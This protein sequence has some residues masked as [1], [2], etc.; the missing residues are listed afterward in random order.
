MADYIAKASVVKVAVGPK[1][2]SRVA[3]FIRAGSPIPEGVDQDLLDALA[4]RGLIQLTPDNPAEDTAADD[5][6]AEA[7]AKAEADAAAKA[8]TD[9]EAAA[10]LAK[11]K[12][13]TSD[14]TTTA[15]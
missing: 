13:S 12:A 3:R 5:A 4:E 6:Q 7:A 15:K 2:G 9:A 1:T 10:V 14:K 8:A 11:S